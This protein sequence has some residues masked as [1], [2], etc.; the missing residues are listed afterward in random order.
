MKN[1]D[2]LRV[3]RQTLASFLMT[4]NFFLL[5]PSFILGQS[6]GIGTLNPDPSAA[7][8]IFS[9]NKGVLFPVVS[10]QNS[11]DKTTIPNPAPGLVIY[12]NNGSYPSGRGHYYN[13]GSNN[14]PDWTPLSEFKLP[15]YRA[16]SSPT[17][18]FTIE[19]YADNAAAGA[20]RGFSQKSTGVHGESVTGIGVL[21]KNVF[22]TALEVDGRMK[23]S[24][25][26]QTPAAG[27]VLTSDASGNATWQG[28]V[29]FSATG[30]VGGGSQKIAKD[31]QS[32]VAFAKE[33]YDLGGNYNVSNGSPH[34]TFI[35]PVN[36]IYHFNASIT[37]IEIS[38]DSYIS[39]LRFIRKRGNDEVNLS[40]TSLSNQD[41]V[42]SLILSIDCQLQQ[43]DQIYV[44]VIQNTYDY[45]DLS[46]D[47]SASHFSGRLVV[48]N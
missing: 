29:A 4:A 48:K 40:E 38:L 32:R 2:Q 43:G 18:N 19:N 42:N 16:P 24:G 12:N 39:S 31:A 41:G 1:H 13:A 14:S 37:W 6:V 28:A 26:G 23:I 15:Y 5:A 9:N 21:A 47:D 22:G 35:A 33:Q 3:I 30:V 27:K 46:T 20:I 44:E 11:S 8:Q 10:I 34:S 36:G 25:I 17:V 7:L 45:M